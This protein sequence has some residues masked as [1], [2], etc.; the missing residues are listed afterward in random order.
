MLLSP[1]LLCSPHDRPMNPRDEVL[2]Q[3]RD[4]IR[5]MADWEDGML[6]PRNNNLTG[7]CMPGS[8]IDQRKKQW[9]TK[10]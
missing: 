7:V 10:L 5:E 8:G 4:F 6:A 9:G 3:E 2:R 1:S